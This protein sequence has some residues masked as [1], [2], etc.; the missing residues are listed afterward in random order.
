MSSLDLGMIFERIEFLRDPYI[1]DTLKVQNY[2]QF[3]VLRIFRKQLQTLKLFR[4]Q[5]QSKLH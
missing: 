3:L 1:L 4:V 2:L 5:F